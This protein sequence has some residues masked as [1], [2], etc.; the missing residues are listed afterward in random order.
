MK[1]VLSVDASSFDFFGS[2]QLDLF[3]KDNLRAHMTRVAMVR[4][5]ATNV[6]GKHTNVETRIA[7]INIYNAAKGR[8]ERS[9]LRDIMGMTRT[10][11]HRW[12]KDHEAYY[13]GKLKV[14]TVVIRK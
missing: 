14:R 9:L 13:A 11:I 12:K 6:E 4:Q 2:A 7:F 8:G 1:T 3:K 5:L 10:T